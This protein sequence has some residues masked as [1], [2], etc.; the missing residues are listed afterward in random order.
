VAALTRT[1]A[2]VREAFGEPDL[3]WIAGTLGNGLAQSGHH[4]RVA[5]VNRAIAQAA[6]TIPHFYLV[7]TSDLDDLGDR[8]HFSTPALR[9]MGRRY[10]DAWARVG[11]ALPKGPVPRQAGTGGNRP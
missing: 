6:E 7:E 1:V 2:A 11:P 4:P 3:P 10:A 5:A 8:V 9:E